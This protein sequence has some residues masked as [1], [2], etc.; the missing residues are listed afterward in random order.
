M[1]DA[2][3]VL[4]ENDREIV[5]IIKGK[6]KIVLLNK[7]DL[8]TKV[9]EEMIEELFGD[10]EGACT[11]VKISARDGSGMEKFEQTIKDMFSIGE[12]KSSNDIVV[13]NIRHIKALEETDS[14]LKMIKKSIEEG[15][16]EDFFYIDLMAAYASLG[17]I[18]GEKV[19]DDLVDE[20]FSKFCMGK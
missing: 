5:S 1:V 17:K 13:T 15:L 14:Y 10:E 11:I 8:E 2:S 3:S 12:M 9:K 19:E 7:S 20:I 18:T 16:T 4:D 6:K